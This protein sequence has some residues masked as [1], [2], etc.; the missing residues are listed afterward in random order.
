MNETYDLK[1]LKSLI[2]T[3]VANSQN[4]ML[5]GCLIHVCR[6]YSSC[7]LH[8]VMIQFKEDLI[9]VMVQLAG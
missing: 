9:I 4:A 8:I 3:N 7:D 5:L 2:E 6:I 1:Y